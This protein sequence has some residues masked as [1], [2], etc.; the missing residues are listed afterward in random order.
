MS[1]QFVPTSWGSWRGTLRWPGAFGNDR[2]YLGR[3]PAGKVRHRSTLFGGKK[4]SAEREL[5]RLVADQDRAPAV[6]PDDVSRAWGPATTINDAIEGWR[7][8]GWDDLSPSTVRRYESM[9]KVH[10]TDSIGRRRIAS[11]GPYD[12][13]RYFRDLKT[14][15]LSQAS[16][17][18]IRAVLHRSCRLARKW[19]SNVLPNPITDTELP[20]WSLAEQGP[21]VRSPTPDE[22]RRLL[23]AGRDDD[24]PRMGPFVRLVAAT[25]MRR[26]EACALRWND[27]DWERSALRVDE[28]LVA[29]SGGVK[30]RGPKTRASLRAIAVD[31]DTLAE[32]RSLHD[33]QA[34]LAAIAEVAMDSDAF[35]FSYEPGGHLP[36]YPDTMSHAFSALRSR[37]SSAHLA[38]AVALW[39]YAAR[40]AAWA[41]AATTGDPLAETLH[42]LLAASPAGLT[43]TQI[44]DH[45]GRNRTGPAID[46]ALAALATAGRAQCRRVDGPGRP[47]QMWAASP[48]TSN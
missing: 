38:A 19:S 21:A 26:G 24:D 44:R 10:I 37:A 16:V 47:A 4:R 20:E 45:L 12:V 35:V 34:E 33:R 31:A 3:D 2:I 9:V 5:A 32:L 27:V 25:G 43:R 22:V 42:H 14:T 46:D 18:Q 7:A 1:Q 48:P 11:L 41:L 6:V 15:G 39:D 36:P 28:A 40:S 23:A 30:V 8:N 29:D 17:R 13:E